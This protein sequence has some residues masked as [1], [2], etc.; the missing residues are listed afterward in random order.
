ME[1]LIQKGNE[2][3]FEVLELEVDKTT[4]T[5]AKASDEQRLSSDG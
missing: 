1:C 3:L 4:M 2:L 5:E